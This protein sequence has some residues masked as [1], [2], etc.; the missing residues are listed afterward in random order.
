MKKILRELTKSEN[1][2]Y[3]VKEEITTQFAAP[4]HF[5]QGYEFTYIVKGHGKFYGGDSLL[6]FTG[7]DL[8]LFGIGFPHYF[9]NDKSFIK[10]GELAHSIVIQ[11]DDDFLG[12]DFYLQP[13]FLLVKTLLKTAHLGIKITNP[14]IQLKRLMIDAPKTS[15]LK[16]LINLLRILETV[17]SLKKE[18]T[19]T[20]STD[21][22]E[23]S[24]ITKK[25]ANKLDEVY[26]Y[27]LENFKERITSQKAASL[28]FMNKS[29]FCRYFKRRT[30][31]TLSQFVNHVR[32]TH[33]IHLLA[34]EDMSIS[35]VCFE[36]G[37]DN[38]SYFN[39]QFKTVTGKT[40]YA[41][42]K[43]FS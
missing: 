14:G 35:K 4:F 36:C 19:T 31:K 12:G 17:A 15:G 27:V 9:I 7:G 3:I 40:P 18:E 2:S 11:F 24:I 38:L 22:F 33:A 25:K 30:N 1:S 29:A 32:V 6:N 13:E 8:Y 42:R 41:Y 21:I 23:N 34:E 28:A 20:I 39:R 26:K 10:S 37:F 16:G 43:E 5:H